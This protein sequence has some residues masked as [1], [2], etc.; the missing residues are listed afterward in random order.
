MK[1]LAVFFHVLVFVSI[2]ISFAEA[3]EYINNCPVPDNLKIIEPDGRCS[4][5]ETGASFRRLGR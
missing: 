2:F 3:G 5:P 4:A 1:K